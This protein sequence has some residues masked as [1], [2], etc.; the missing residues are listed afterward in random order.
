MNKLKDL[1]IALIIRIG[2]Q[3]GLQ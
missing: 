1:L 3:L 2:H